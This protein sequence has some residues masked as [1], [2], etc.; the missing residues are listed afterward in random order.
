MCL[1]DLPL[2]YS[3][4][5]INYFRFSLISSY[6]PPHICSWK[7]VLMI[8]AGRKGVKTWRTWLWHW[9]L[10]INLVRMH[11]STSSMSWSNLVSWK[12]ISRPSLHRKQYSFF[13][14]IL[15]DPLRVF[16]LLLWPKPLWESWSD[17][18]VIYSHDFRRFC[19]WFLGPSI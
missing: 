5:L 10:K 14:F 18:H 7:F 2:P 11:Y 19:F 17:G 12:D 13:L 9:C 1:P 4:R 15:L 8:K 6:S 3:S 16:Y